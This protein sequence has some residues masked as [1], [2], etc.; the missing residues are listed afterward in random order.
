MLILVS[1]GFYLLLFVKTRANVRFAELMPF[2]AN[3]QCERWTSRGARYTQP[4]GY[5]YEHANGNTRRMV[6]DMYGP[7]E[8]EAPAPRLVRRNETESYDEN[9]DYDVSNNDTSA[10]S[11]KTP[12]AKIR[13][14]YV[15]IKSTKFTL[16]GSYFLFAFL[17]EPGDD[18]SDWAIDENLVGTH[19]VLAP[20]DQSEEHKEKHMLVA[21]SIP[22]TKALSDAVE[23]DVIDSLDEKDVAPYLRENLHW[24]MTKVSME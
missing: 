13:D 22:L 5:T 10:S 7:T 1:D 4:F 19:C 23:A 6:N 11:Y 9:P 16:D 17:G 15:T 8:E 20:I 21:G 12:G 2:S 14:Y 3:G 24:R 18:P